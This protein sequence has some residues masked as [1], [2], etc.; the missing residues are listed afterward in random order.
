[1]R[2]STEYGSM[3]RFADASAVVL[4]IPVSESTY[5]EV[6]IEL[7]DVIAHREDYYYDS[8]GLVLAGFK[9]IYKRERHYYCSD[10]VRELLVRFGIED[11]EMFEPIVQPMH[12]LDIPDGNIIYR[13]R[14]CDYDRTAV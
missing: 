7:K 13:G 4:A 2:E 8:I 1:M 14:L 12:F 3:K 6:E 10:F 11:S 5:N 9:I